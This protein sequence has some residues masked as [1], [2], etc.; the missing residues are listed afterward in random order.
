VYSLIIRLAEV[1]TLARYE[2]LRRATDQMH[3]KTGYRLGLHIRF[4]RDVGRAPLPD[5]EG[6]DTGQTCRDTGCAVDLDLSVDQLGG[7][8]ASLQIVVCLDVME[9]GVRHDKGD[10]RDRQYGDGG[11]IDTL[12]A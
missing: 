6:D 5:A 8:A 1:R 7:I 3:E 11:V 4:P 2:E 10:D 12:R 9:A